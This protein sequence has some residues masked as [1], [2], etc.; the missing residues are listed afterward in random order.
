MTREEMER[1]LRAAGWIAR[2]RALWLRPRT[3]RHTLHDPL[4]TTEEAWRELA[5]QRESGSVERE[6]K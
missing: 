4:L 6:G 2:G 5:Q 1:E 3:T